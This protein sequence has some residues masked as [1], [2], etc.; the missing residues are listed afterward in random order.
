MLLLGGERVG[1]L[2]EG[3]G[4]LR[5]GKKEVHLHEPRFQVELK[6]GTVDGAVPLVAAESAFPEWKDFERPA[7]SPGV[8]D[9]GFGELR[10]VGLI[11]VY[12]RLGE[13]RSTV[14]R[15]TMERSAPRLANGFP[16][17]R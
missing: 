1:G 2:A 6:Q 10:T 9:R 17:V 4:R 3:A 14:T 7:R 13:T 16:E 11:T 5:S 8:T 12:C 15:T